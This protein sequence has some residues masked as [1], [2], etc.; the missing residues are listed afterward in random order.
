[1]SG[2][3]GANRF[4]PYLKSVYCNLLYTRMLLK[5]LK[6]RAITHQYVQ[7]SCSFRKALALSFHCYKFVS[8]RVEFV[9]NIVLKIDS[10]V[11]KH[12]KVET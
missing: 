3:G 8:Q 12:F 9:R 6:T 5:V 7:S 2:G 11:K 10:E 1:M 4:I